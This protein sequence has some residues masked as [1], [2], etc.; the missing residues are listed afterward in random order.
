MTPAAIDELLRDLSEYAIS[1]DA[2]NYGLPQ[3][4]K[5][6]DGL[7]SLVA[8]WAAGRSQWRPISEAPDDKP[9][10]VSGFCGD[11]ESKPRWV[12]LAI[13]KVG[14]WYECDIGGVTLDETNPLYP[15]THFIEFTAPEP[16][17]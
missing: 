1:C 7:R 3:Y 16:P 4:G 11:D 10:F 13:Q 15:P 17:K 6:L 5:S 8:Q 9:C 2:G 14:N 12:E